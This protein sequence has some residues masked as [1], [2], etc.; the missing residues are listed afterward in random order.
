MTEAGARPIVRQ[1]RDLQPPRYFLR[2]RVVDHRRQIEG[3]IAAEV[4][5]NGQALDDH[6]GPRLEVYR[7]HVDADAGSGDSG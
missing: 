3:F 5:G 7:N 1:S 2:R 4:A 6:L